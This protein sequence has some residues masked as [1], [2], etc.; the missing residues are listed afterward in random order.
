MNIG[1]YITEFERLYDMVQVHDMKYADG[2]LAY[3]LLINANISEEKQSMCRAT[4]GKLTFENIKKQLKVIHDLTG[5]EIETG[6]HSNVTVKEEQV[7]EAEY[8]YHDNFYAHAR[9]SWRGNRGSRG[10]SR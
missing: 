9:D 6:T 10:N 7:F 2:V 8:G 3:K 4:M 1:E 5:T